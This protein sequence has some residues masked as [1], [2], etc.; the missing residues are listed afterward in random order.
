MRIARIN[1][2]VPF[3]T[4]TLLQGT[5]KNIHGNIILRRRRK[6]APHKRASKQ[7]LMRQRNQIRL[8]WEKRKAWL[9]PFWA[10]WNICYLSLFH[11]PSTNHVLWR[12]KER[13]G[14]RKER[15]M[16]EH[17]CH[18]HSMARFFPL[19]FINEC[20]LPNLVLL[21]F[22]HLQ[23]RNNHNVQWKKA[24]ALNISPK[25]PKVYVPRRV[26]I[27]CNKPTLACEFVAYSKDFFDFPLDNSVFIPGYCICH[28]VDTSPT[29]AGSYC[30][31]ARLTPRLDRIDEGP[32]ACLAFVCLKKNVCPMLNTAWTFVNQINQILLIQW[33]CLWIYFC[34]NIGDQTYYPTTILTHYKSYLL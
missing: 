1:P 31:S 18:L 13:A 17:V 5:E 19:L 15:K 29:H 26:Y 34:F 23:F 7:Y 32:F 33:H 24:A 25:W 28:S 4:P 2:Q 27:A 22:L 6:R 16:G 3:P 11:A 9:R 12:E 8:D 21:L 14:S 10:I 20:L 30:I